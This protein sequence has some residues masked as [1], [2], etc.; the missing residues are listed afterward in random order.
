M[1]NY[2]AEE[3]AQMLKIL[4]CAAVTEDA[5]ILTADLTVPMENWTEQ[6]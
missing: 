4:P 6:K 3:G 5:H 1:V 2:W